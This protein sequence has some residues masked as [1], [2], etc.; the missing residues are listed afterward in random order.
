M[1]NMIGDLQPMIKRGDHG[2]IRPRL[3]GI[4][5]RRRRCF[6]GATVAGRGGPLWSDSPWVERPT[7]VLDLSGTLPRRKDARRHPDPRVVRGGTLALAI[8]KA[9]GRTVASVHRRRHYSRDSQEAALYSR[10]RALAAPHQ[11]T[12]EEL[13]T[14]LLASVSRGARICDQRKSPE[15]SG[16][17]RPEAQSYPAGQG[18]PFKCATWLRYGSLDQCLRCPMCAVVVLSGRLV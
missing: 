4:K 3:R 18:T 8:T 1:D 16:V 2:S 13:K 11:R 10:S 17:G 6:T 5:Q 14:E 12:S 9:C 7:A 15:R